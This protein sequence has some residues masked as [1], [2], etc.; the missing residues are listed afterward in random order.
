[1]LNTQ[2]QIAI[3]DAV[4]EKVKDL[5]KLLDSFKDGVDHKSLDL[6]KDWFVEAKLGNESV[7][8]NQL[9]NV[10]INSCLYASFRD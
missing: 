9:F 2:E 5:A 4:Y 6:L 8:V 3:H 7:A 10:C 1:M